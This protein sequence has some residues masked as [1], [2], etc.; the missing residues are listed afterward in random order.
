MYI[1]RM[2]AIEAIR[3]TLSRTATWFTLKN[4]L[5]YSADAFGGSTNLATDEVRP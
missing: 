4:N 5:Q 3:G 1:F 2:G